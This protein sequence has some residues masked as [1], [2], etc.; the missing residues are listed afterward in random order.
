MYIAR[1]PAL[2]Q[3]IWL[4]GS[5]LTYMAK[6]LMTVVMFIKT[7][8]QI[9]WATIIFNNLH[10]RLRD[11]GN[12]HKTNTTKDVEFKGAQILNNVL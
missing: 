6:K 3:G 1:M 11:L 10:S 2:I 12:P 4:K 9:N 5:H 7:K 8:M